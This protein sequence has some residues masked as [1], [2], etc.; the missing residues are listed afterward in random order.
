LAMEARWRGQ[1]V[2]LVNAAV[3]AGELRRELDADQF[4]WE[5]CGIYL[6]HHASHRFIRDPRALERAEA[7]FESL[8]ERSRPATRKPARPSASGVQGKPA[9]RK[10]K[11]RGPKR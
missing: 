7:A 11:A 8:V 9:G 4:V 1:L 6:N 2:Q 3:A 5:L 10:P